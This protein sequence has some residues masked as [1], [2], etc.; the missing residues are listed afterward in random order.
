MQTNYSNELEKA[1]ATT[2]REPSPQLRFM[3]MASSQ[4]GTSE[5]A[6]V[7]LD[8]AIAKVHELVVLGIPEVSIRRFHCDN[9]GNC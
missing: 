3:V 1:F 4:Y 9:T 8:A 2:Q 6:F 5:H 7:D